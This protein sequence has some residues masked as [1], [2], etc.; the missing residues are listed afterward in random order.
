[1]DQLDMILWGIFWKQR[2]KLAGS[3]D[4]G[5]PKF[6]ASLPKLSHIRSQWAPWFFGL[7]IKNINSLLTSVFLSSSFRIPGPQVSWRSPRFQILGA[8]LAPRFVC[9][10]SIWV[11]PLEGCGKLDSWPPQDV[12]LYPGMSDLKQKVQGHWHSAAFTSKECSPFTWNHEKGCVSAVISAWLIEVHFLNNL[13][14]MNHYLYRWRQSMA[15]CF[16]V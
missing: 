15:G 4:P 12:Q 10:I 1:M 8:R 14:T 3:R 9:L 16:L 2:S 6:V 13:L 7:G 11:F 5:A